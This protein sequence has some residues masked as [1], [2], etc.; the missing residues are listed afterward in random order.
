MKDD[1]QLQRW[2]N[3]DQGKD[4]VNTKKKERLWLAISKQLKILEFGQM[5][6]LMQRLRKC[7][8]YNYK[9]ISQL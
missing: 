8:T 9:S 7:Y 6:N 2:K 1:G 3:F 4:E 5:Q